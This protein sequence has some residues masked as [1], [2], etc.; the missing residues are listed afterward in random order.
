[1]SQK[2]SVQDLLEAGVH[3]GHQLKRWNPKMKEFVYGVRNGIHIIDLTKT[4][5]QLA[6][7]A[8]FLQ[9]VAMD[10]GDILFVGTKRQAQEIIK[11]AA[12]NAGMFHISERWLGGTLTNNATI[13][14]SINR[15]LTMQKEL[16]NEDASLSKK[17]LSSLSKKLEKLHKNLDGISEM[18]KLPAA[19]VVVDICNEDIAVKEAKKLKIPIVGIVDTNGNPGR[20]EYPIP[21]NDD[22]IRSIR[23]LVSVLSDAVAAAAEVY[24]K[25]SAEERAEKAKKKAEEDVQKEKLKEE[26]KSSR[27]FDPSKRKPAIRRLPAVRKAPLKA[28]ADTK[29][30]TKEEVKA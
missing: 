5:Y 28:P 11:Q 19:V 10:G 14:K 7:A 26:K 17:E 30:E 3:F 23:I 4:M 20:V 27:D 25:K 12:Q 8:R 13:R 15:M 21:G 18:K 29:E 9:S 2:I 6:D 24:R 22:A 16:E 1:M